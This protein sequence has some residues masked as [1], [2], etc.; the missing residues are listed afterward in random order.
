MDQKNDEFAIAWPP[1]L[2]PMSTDNPDTRKWA[3]T[4]RQ[5]AEERRKLLAALRWKDG[6]LVRN[7]FGERV[8][9]KPCYDA[10]GQRVGITECCLEATPC[11]RHGKDVTD[12]R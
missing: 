3:E 11:E 8:W 6:D 1:G 9:L 2:R 10:V 4:V 5:E 7:H 12:G